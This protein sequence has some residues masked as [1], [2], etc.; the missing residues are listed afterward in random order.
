MP[1]SL[2]KLLKT[3]RSSH[4]VGYKKALKTHNEVILKKT[5]DHCIDMIEI[6]WEKFINTESHINRT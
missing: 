6:A 1:L 4:L 5:Q 2:Y 3:S